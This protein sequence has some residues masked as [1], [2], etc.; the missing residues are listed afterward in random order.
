MAA[1]SVHLL[2]QMYRDIPLPAGIQI[3]PAHRNMISHAVTE[4]LT[5]CAGWEASAA[6]NVSSSNADSN[7]T[8][9]QTGV[10]TI[11]TGAYV[12]FGGALAV[13]GAAFV[14]ALFIRRKF[15]R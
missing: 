7:R 10:E 12:M 5:L 3:L 2:I 9:L 11:L 4:N 8:S 15:P 13:L 6:S 14:S 1:R